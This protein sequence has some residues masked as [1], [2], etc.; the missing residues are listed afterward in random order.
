MPF[1]FFVCVVVLSDSEVTRFIGLF[2]FSILRLKYTYTSTYITVTF[3]NV[4]VKAVQGSLGRRIK[5]LQRHD[6]WND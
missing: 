1:F 3:R 6:M 2:V 4:K 5:K